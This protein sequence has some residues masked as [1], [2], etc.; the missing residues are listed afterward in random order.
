MVLL[1]SKYAQEMS[2][3]PCKD[4]L[5]PREMC[6]EQLWFVTHHPKMCT[7]NVEYTVWNTC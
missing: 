7:Q 1:L 2:H 3:S 6:L 5:R 4:G